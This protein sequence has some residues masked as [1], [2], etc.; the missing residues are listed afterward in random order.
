MPI[1]VVPLTQP[2]DFLNSSIWSPREKDLKTY[3]HFDRRISSAKI[4]ELSNSPERVAKHAFFPL[5]L[6]SEEWTRYRGA[7]SA[8]Q[9]K[10]RPIRY[11]ARTDAAIYAKYR[12]ELSRLYEKEVSARDLDQEPIAYRRIANEYGGGNKCNIDFAHDIFK[13]I[14]DTGSCVACVVDISSYFESLDHSKILEKWK[15]LIGQELPADHM[16]VFRSVTNYCVVD[17][18]QMASRLGLYEKNSS[19]NRFER[20]Q[21]KIDRLRTSG[22]T[23]LCSPAEFRNLICGGDNTLPSLLRKNR[24][25]FGIPQGTPISDLIA[26]FYLLD[27][28]QRLKNFADANGGLYRR[29]SDDIILILPEKSDSDFL[30]LK[31]FLQREIKKEGERL[32]IQDKKVAICKFEPQMDGSLKYSHLFGKSSKNGLEYLGFQFNGRVV[33]LKDATL[34]NAWRKIKRRS[35]GF[36]RR[37]VRRY[38]DK[39]AGWIKANYPFQK[40]LV[41]FISKVTHSQDVGFESWTFRSYVIRCMKKFSKLNCIFTKQVRHYLANTQT[42]ISNDLEKAI[43]IHL[44]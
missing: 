29:Y 6:Y 20:R 10:R 28:D 39:G 41:K 11:S 2:E 44:K 7:A 26:N 13:F 35:Y 43:K 30:E 19:G 1:D 22:H 31:A 23:Q 36:A 8:R 18:E 27:F 34:S 33:S 14:R 40:L 42:L 32:E 38:R 15:I 21:R 5:L 9:K 3:L 25:G 17:Y 16:A 37:Y 12:S 24:S 4:T